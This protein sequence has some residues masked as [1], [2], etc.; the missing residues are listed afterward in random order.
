M[1]HNWTNIVLHAYQTPPPKNPI[2]HISFTSRKPINWLVF[3]SWFLVCLTLQDLKDKKGKNTGLDRRHPYLA[4]HGFLIQISS[5]RLYWWFD[6]CCLSLDKIHKLNLTGCSSSSSIFQLKKG[7][8]FLAVLQG[9]CERW[10][11]A[12]VTNLLSCCGERW[13]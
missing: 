2:S 6:W 4:L 12:R 5:V 13:C 7:F 10:Q 1:N 9:P 3:S 8:L 11:R